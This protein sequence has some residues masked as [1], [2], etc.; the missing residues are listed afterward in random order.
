MPSILVQIG[1]PYIAIIKWTGLIA[2]IPHGYQ[3]CDG[4]NSTPD[5]RGK[6]VRGA[7]ASTEHGGTGGAD[8]VTLDSTMIPNHNHGTTDPTHSHSFGH[9]SDHLVAGSGNS[10]QG[11]T[12]TTSSTTPSI[13]INSQGGGG[14]HNNLPQYYEV[15][16][17]AKVST[18]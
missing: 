13:T 8:T 5:L 9:D 11:G 12:L 3:I 17:I 7:P 6:F 2:N 16:Y 4:T 18:R 10:I 15:I 14:S 1:M